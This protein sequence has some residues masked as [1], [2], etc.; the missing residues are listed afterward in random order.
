MTVPADLA[1]GFIKVAEISGQIMT[2]SYSMYVPD[3][4]VDYEWGVQAIDNGKRGG[5]FAKSD[6]N[7]TTTGLKKKEVSDVNVYVSD[8]NVC[9]NV[10]EKNAILKVTDAAASLI[11]VVSVSGKGVLENLNKGIYFI[12]V[13]ADK[14]IKVFKIIL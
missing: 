5:K 13:I 8:G 3:E 1:T 6:F 12:S 14:A 2:T 10:G 4:N 11:S 7:P 9:Y